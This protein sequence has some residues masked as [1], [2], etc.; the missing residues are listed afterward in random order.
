MQIPAIDEA[1]KAGFYVAVVDGNP[2]APGG[3]LADE[4]NPVDLKDL[5]G[6]LDYGRKLKSCKNLAGVF[7]CATD[8]SASVA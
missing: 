5:K 2:S 6:L 7:T 1:K 4:F 3:V 8:F